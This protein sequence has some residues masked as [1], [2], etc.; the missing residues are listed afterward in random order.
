MLIDLSVKVTLASNADALIN[1]KMV[2]FGHLGTHFDVMNKEF[3]L[4]FTKRDGI[5]FDV[6]KVINREIEI[7][8]I[9]ISLVLA[10]MFVVFYTGFIEQHEY[11]SKLYFS[12]HPQISNGLIDQLLDR[13]IS[14]IGVDF[15]GLRRGAEHTPKDQYCA[16]R[17]V[18]IIENLCNLG[19][20]LNNHNNKSFT[21]NI[22]PINFADMSGL[23]CRVT[24]E[25]TV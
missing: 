18:F 7:T 25:V 20:V 10:E 21:A 23:P 4:E 19:K 14:I 3:P 2:S 13:N 8:D 9:N 16:D 5:V 17:G 6:S 24:A 11:G 12:D 22:Y 15:A 1:E